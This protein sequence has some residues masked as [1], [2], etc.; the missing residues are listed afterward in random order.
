MA[1][2]ITYPFAPVPAVNAPV[3]TFSVEHP[4]PFAAQVES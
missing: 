3:V 1:W 2:T 4:V